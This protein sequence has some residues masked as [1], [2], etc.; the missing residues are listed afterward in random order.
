VYWRTNNHLLLKSLYRQQVLTYEDNTCEDGTKQTDSGSSG[1]AVNSRCDPK[2]LD[3][4]LKQAAIQ[5]GVMLLILGCSGVARID[6]IVDSS[7]DQIYFNEINTLPGSLA[8][9]LWAVKS[10]GTLYR[11]LNRMIEQPRY[12]NAQRH[13]Y[14]ETGLRSLFR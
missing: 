11:L 7:S 9:Y 2:D 3:T 13:L 4:E 12:G 5:Y 8:Y 14:G 1:M 6:F 10:S